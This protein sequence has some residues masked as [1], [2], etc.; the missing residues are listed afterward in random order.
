MEYTLRIEEQSNPEDVAIVRQ[1]LYE[2]NLPY[3]GDDNYT[4]LRIFLR[5]K[6][7]AVLGGLL[8]TTYWGYLN[9]EVLWIKE[10]HRNQGYG[11]RLLSAAEEE[12]IKRGCQY[13]HL[14]THNFQALAFYQEHG[15][16]VVGE[17][18]DLP[19]GYSRYLLK[20][21]LLRRRET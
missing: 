6:N 15:Y 17:L 14:D 11:Q 2:Y 16:K 5:D 19:P 20:K 3:A 21:V 12:T 7:G 9:I 8:G 13:A 4:E 1:G 10:D 18:E